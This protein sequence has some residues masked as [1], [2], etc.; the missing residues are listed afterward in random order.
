MTI[1]GVQVRQILIVGKQSSLARR[2]GTSYWYMWDFESNLRWCI[3]LNPL[4]GDGD[5]SFS[6]AIAEHLG[7]ITLT[8]SCLDELSSLESNIPTALAIVQEVEKRGRV[9][10]GIDCRKLM[11]YEVLKSERFERIIFN[12]P[13]VPGKNNIKRNREL[14]FDF[15]ISAKQIMSRGGEIYVALC[16]GQGK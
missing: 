9:L 7:N 16:E 13:H 11:E 14:L 4:A 8:S 6:R 1:T 10:F 5:F 12:F 3:Y 2:H 15:L